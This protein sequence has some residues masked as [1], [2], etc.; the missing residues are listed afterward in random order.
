MHATFSSSRGWRPRVEHTFALD[1]R[2][3]AGIPSLGQRQHTGIHYYG[4]LRVQ[5]A[6]NGVLL[7]QVTIATI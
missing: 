3:V 1:G 4:T 2:T 7:M 6:I 5:R